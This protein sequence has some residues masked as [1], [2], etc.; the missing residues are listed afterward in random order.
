MT[1]ILRALVAELKGHEHKTLVSASSGAYL[2]VSCTR[3][4]GDWNDGRSRHISEGI[5]KM[6]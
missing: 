3:D 5:N 2:A 4:S 6:A 1:A